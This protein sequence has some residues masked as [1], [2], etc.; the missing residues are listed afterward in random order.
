MDVLIVP[1]IWKETFSLITLE[2]LSYGVPVIVSDNVGA[3]DLVSI[4]NSEFIYRTELELE[5]LLNK[6][7]I[8]RSS[9]INFNSEILNK[10]WSHSIEKHI[11]VLNSKLYK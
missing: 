7:L 1:S 10:E 8:N 5:K 3:K 2:A 9:L 4:Y 6:I 11:E